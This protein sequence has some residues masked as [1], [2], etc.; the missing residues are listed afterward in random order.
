M[1]SFIS[2]LLVVSSFALA[3]ETAIA[4][5][6]VSDAPVQRPATKPATYV[7]VAPTYVAPSYIGW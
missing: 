2:V 3:P 4:A 5:G 7:Y 1:K 6:Q